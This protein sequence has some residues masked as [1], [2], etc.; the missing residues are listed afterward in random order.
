[1]RLA[2]IVFTSSLLSSAATYT[3]SNNNGV[4]DLGEEYIDYWYDDWYIPLSY[5]YTIEDESPALILD[6][7]PQYDF[8]C[9]VI[10]YLDEALIINEDFDGDGKLDVAEDLNQNGI[11]DIGEDV[12]GDGFLDID[13]DIDNDN[14][15]D[16]GTEIFI[17]HEDSNVYH[18]NGLSNSEILDFD[19]NNYT[20]DIDSNDA[21]MGENGLFYEECTDYMN[22]VWDDVIYAMDGTILA[23]AEEFVDATNGVYDLG[24]LFTDS[25]GNGQWD[26]GEFFADALNGVYDEGEAFTDVAKCLSLDP[27]WMPI[28][29][30]IMPPY[31]EFSYQWYYPITNDSDGFPIPE[32]FGGRSNFFQIDAI[33]SN[34]GI[35]RVE[36]TEH[37]PPN[38]FIVYDDTE[39]VFDLD[40]YTDILEGN[41]VS[42]DWMPGIGWSITKSHSFEIK[43]V[44]DTDNDGLYDYKETGTGIY[45]SPVDTGTDPYNPDTDADSLSDGYEITLGTNPNLADTDSD[46]LLDYAETNTGDYISPDDT[47]TNP[48]LID[49]SGDG[50]KDG[51]VVNAGFNPNVD[52]SPL[53][54]LDENDFTISGISDLRAGSVTIQIVDGEANISMDVESSTDL[55]NWAIEG[56][57]DMQIAIE[58]GSDKKFFRFK[59]AE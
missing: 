26:P 45:V 37:N 7:T 28:G 48:L 9:G 55:T 33:E 21:N 25:N 22:G 59:M 54:R 41:E 42:R 51:S 8:G 27:P 52:Y 53:F 3:D 14:I 5:S 58:A 20:S 32:Q 39:L 11:M 2:L 4:W 57:T 47:G 50:L 49:T 43:V 13:E 40:R 38:W 1:M 12:D 30:P 29:P 46:G 17:N 56:T 34:E 36:V 31:Q 15:L 16:I 18:R 19:I 24:E 35:W 10:C 23:P 44:K 6:A